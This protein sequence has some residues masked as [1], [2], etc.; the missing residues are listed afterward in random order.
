MPIKKAALKHLRQTKVRTRRNQEVRRA[1][2]RILKKTHRSHTD[3][4]QEA[5]TKNLRE[6]LKTIDKARQH[7]IL[8]QNTAAR[9]KSRLM[10]R[11]AAKKA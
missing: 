3:G 8:K 6:A 9:K 4:N 10:R 11:Y 5:L 7:G 2:Q 1:L